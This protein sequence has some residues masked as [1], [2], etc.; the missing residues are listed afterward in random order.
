MQNH[1]STS[2]KTG[3]TIVEMKVKQIYQ[4]YKIPPN[5][6]DHMIRAAAVGTFIAAHWNKKDELDKTAIVQALLLHDMGNIIKFDFRF[7]HLLGEE[8]KNADYWK[9]V[10]DEF[11]EKYGNDEHVATIKIAQEIGLGARAFELLN[12]IGSAKLDQAL[13][14]DDWNKKIVC[15]SDFRV[16][17][18]G[19][20][21]VNQRFDE[22]ISRYK[23]RNH[24]LGKIEETEKKRA[25]CLQLQKQLQ[26][27]V[28]FDLDQ[29]S[30]NE[31]EGYI[32]TLSA[33]D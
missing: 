20:V 26:T 5:L 24:K 29:L 10:Q 2:Q 12:A 8:E 33:Y 13:K 17:P 30:N 6:Q 31:I 25:F 32:N 15:Y 27:K 18:H 23:D 21:T 1:L 7:S 28:D 3:E 14:T 22:I 11:K 4:N 9:K 16:D 19:I